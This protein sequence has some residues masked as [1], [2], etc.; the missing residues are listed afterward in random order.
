MASAS[1][2]PLEPVSRAHGDLAFVTRG[3]WSASDLGTVLVALDRAYLA[4]LLA[5]ALVRAQDR[6]ARAQVR[7]SG[8]LLGPS[9]SAFASLPAGLW[10]GDVIDECLA[11]PGLF[12]G[13][14]DELVIERI[15][16]ASPGGFHLKGL[17]EPIRQLR[18][19][20]KDMF[21]RNRQER[22]RGELALLRE[23]LQLA[24]QFRLTGEPLDKLSAAVLD[25]MAQLKPFLVSQRLLLRYD[26]ETGAP[27]DDP[28]SVQPRPRRMRK[29]RGT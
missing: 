23:R 24:V 4:I 26:G 14:A 11:D 25:E 29:P 5:F 19:L 21:Y 9:F 7:V 10:S 8:A 16:M 27:A 20:M 1:D 12:I 2:E 6:R 18:E 17:G 13:P 22:Q 15:Q 28:A 3:V